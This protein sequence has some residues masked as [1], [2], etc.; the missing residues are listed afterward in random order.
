MTNSTY[1]IIA[2]NP[3][4]TVVTEY[5][6]DKKGAT[7]Y[8]SENELEREFIR[9]LKAN[10]YEYLNIKENKDLLRNLRVQISKLNDDIEFSEAE[11]QRLLDKYLTNKNESIK[12]KTIKIQNDDHIFNLDLDDGSTKKYTDFG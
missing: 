1:S 9:L 3:N 4:S 2:E 10:G 12:H 6:P 7:R 5:T 11:W 8:Q